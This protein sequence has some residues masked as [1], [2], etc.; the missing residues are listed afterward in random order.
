MS[1][2]DLTQEDIDTGTVFISSSELRKRLTI[3]KSSMHRYITDGHIDALR[4]R[5]RTYFYPE[6]VE[7]YIKLH[8]CGL[9]GIAGK[10]GEK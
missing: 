7:E 3:S 6:A 1:Y 10:K 4:F 2:R 8:N 5:N 9:L